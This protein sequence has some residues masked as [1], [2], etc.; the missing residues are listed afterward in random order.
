M[1]RVGELDTQEVQGVSESRLIGIKRLRGELAILLDRFL[2]IGDCFSISAKLCELFCQVHKGDRPG[3]ARSLGAPCHQSLQDLTRFLSSFE[4]AFS[5]AE[6]AELKCLVQ[7]DC[8]LGSARG[9]PIEDSQ[10]VL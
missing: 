10:R 4:S 5:F 8:L 9:Q 6:L 3:R 2:S 1:T 7:P